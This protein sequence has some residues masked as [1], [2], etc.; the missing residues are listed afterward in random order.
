VTPTEVV[1][2]EKQRHRRFVVRPLLTVSVSQPCEPAN[3]HSQRLVRPF[4]VARTNAG[5]V[6]IAKASRRDYFGYYAWAVSAF[7][8]RIAIDLDQ[9]GEVHSPAKDRRDRRPVGSVAV[10]GQLETALG[11]AIEVVREDSRI[12]GGP[13]PDMVRQDQLGRPLKSGETPNVAEAFGAIQTKASLLFHPAKRPHLVRLNV[14]NTDVTDGLFKEGVTLLVRVHHRPHDRVSADVKLTLKGADRGSFQEKPKREGHY[15]GVATPPIRRARRIIRERPGAAGAAIALGTVR[16]PTEL[17]G[18]PLTM[19]T[20]HTEP[21]FLVFAVR[22]RMRLLTALSSGLTAG[23]VIRPWIRLREFRGF[24]LHSY[25]THKSME[26]NGHGLD[27][28]ELCVYNSNMKKRMGRPPK[29]AGENLS[30]RLDIRVT[31][32][33]RAIYDQAAEAAGMERSEWMRAILNRAGKK[34]LSKKADAQ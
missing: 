19:G 9:R 25:C 29:N 24:S 6:R 16:G 34:H 15:F 26:I 18:L 23:S 8:R 2:G 11:R 20:Q 17:A 7:V 1:V 10:R 33:E 14:V 3:L 21:L 4:D 5:F 27:F 13:L 28:S 31:A 12:V 32:G 30:E 22:R